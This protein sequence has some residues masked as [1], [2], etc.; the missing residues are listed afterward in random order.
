[1]KLLKQIF[2]EG[3]ENWDEF[4]ATRAAMSGKLVL[5]D[6][7]KKALQKY[8]V[9]KTKISTGEVFSLDNIV[10]KRTGGLGISPLHYKEIIGKVAK[11]T[12][13]KDQII[14]ID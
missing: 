5:S 14:E 10:G 11:K 6:F 2:W 9:A 3:T 12:F 1:M 4:L 7:T 8:L 13:Q